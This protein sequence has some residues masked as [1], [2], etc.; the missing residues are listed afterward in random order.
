MWVL[1]IVFVLL[2]RRTARTIALVLLV[3]IGASSWYTYSFFNHGYHEWLDCGRPT[4][5]TCNR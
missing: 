5:G 3:L 4:V 2:F 1:L